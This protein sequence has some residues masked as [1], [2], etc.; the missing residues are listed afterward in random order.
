V[1]EKNGWFCCKEREV[2]FLI[3][4]NMASAQGFAVHQITI[5]H[6][7]ATLEE[8]LAEVNDYPFI[9][10]HQYYRIK[11]PDGEVTWKDRGKLIINTSHMGKVQE[12]IEFEPRENNY[13][14]SHGH[15]ESGNNNFRSTG[16]SLRK[17]GGR[18]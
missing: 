16:P 7:A 5:D 1:E 4:M 14:E 18:V 9:M 17:H 6:E 13:D 12:F 10:G 2:R 15:S 8:F 3:T 11:T